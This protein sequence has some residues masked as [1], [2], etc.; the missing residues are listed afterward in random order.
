[1]WCCQCSL[2]GASAFP[3]TFQDAIESYLNSGGNLFISGAYIGSDLYSKRDSLDIGFAE[4]ILHQF[5]K[6]TIIYFLGIRPAGKSILLLFLLFEGLCQ[7]SN[8]FFKISWV[9]KDEFHP[10]LQVAFLSR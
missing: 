4:N 2:A 9:R 5:L 10:F 1:M 6:A 8:H 3:K 7:L